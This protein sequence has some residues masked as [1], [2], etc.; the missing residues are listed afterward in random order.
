MYVPR[1]A[2]LGIALF[3]LASAAIAGPLTIAKVATPDIN[4]VFDIDCTIIAFG[5]AS[6]NP[7][8]AVV[9]EVEAPGVSRRSM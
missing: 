6:I 9:A 3:A 4:C 5:L 7:P 8:K 2:C 1:G